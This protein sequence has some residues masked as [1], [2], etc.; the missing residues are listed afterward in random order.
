MIPFLLNYREK[1]DSCLSDKSFMISDPLKQFLIFHAAVSN[2]KPD[3]NQFLIRTLNT[4]AIHF[5]KSQH[6]ICADPF[7][8]YPG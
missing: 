2:G 8:R 3:M 5:K 7:V 6:N 4:D 1:L